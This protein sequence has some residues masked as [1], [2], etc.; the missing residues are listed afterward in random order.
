[1]SNVKFKGIIPALI[2]PLDEHGNVL[3]KSVKPIM[4]YML[5]NGVDG[6]YV[7]G[8]TGEGPSLTEEASKDMVEAA[9]E[10]ANSR[11]TLKGEKV[12]IIVHVASADCYRSFRLAKHA[13]DVGADGIASLAPN[14]VFK[15]NA[16]MMTQYYTDLAKCV[17]L[18]VLVYSTPLLGDIDVKEF[19]G[20]LMKVDNIVGTKCTIRDYYQM[21]RLKTIN[22]GDINLING[23]DETLLC[24]LTMGADGGI[25]ST[26]NVMSDRYVKIFDLF[27]QGKIEE[28]R[29]IQLATNNVTCEMLKYPHHMALVKALLKLKG[30]DAGYPTYPGRAMTSEEFDQVLNKMK[31][32]GYEP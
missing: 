32:A 7:T 12:Q 27:H 10:A 31:L 17:D 19:I 23:P 24:G 22:N 9:V 20:N 29:A 5:D 25:G 26:Y 30:F 21:G 6:F 18:P 28:A 16:E 1:M 3:K 11:K 2:T 14:F 4:D 13:Q 8:S 15:H